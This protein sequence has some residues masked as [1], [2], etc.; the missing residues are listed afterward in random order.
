MGEY[1]LNNKNTVKGGATRA[2]LDWRTQWKSEFCSTSVEHKISFPFAS[3]SKFFQ[4][5]VN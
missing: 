4:G 2:K 3:G 1:I 5:H